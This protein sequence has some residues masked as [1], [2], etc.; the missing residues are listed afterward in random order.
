[1]EAISKDSTVW[2]G[3]RINNCKGVKIV[4]CTHADVYRCPFGRFNDEELWKVRQH[5]TKKSSLHKNE[6]IS[7][8]HIEQLL[9]RKNKAPITNSFWSFCQTCK[10]RF[11]NE[12]SEIAHYSQQTGGDKN[13]CVGAAKLRQRVEK[14]Y[15]YFRAFAPNFLLNSDFKIYLNWFEINFEN[16]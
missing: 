7:K 10:L 14:F 16:L 12:D 13:K 5:L 6:N 15:I 2:T 1:M 11:E 8:V 9:I 3:V 4:Y